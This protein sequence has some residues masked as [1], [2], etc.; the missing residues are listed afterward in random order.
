MK[1][2][3]MIMMPSAGISVQLAAV[4]LAAATIQSTLSYDNTQHYYDDSGA[5]D[6]GNHKHQQQPEVAVA[7]TAHHRHHHRHRGIT[8]VTI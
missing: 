8:V 6:S 5:I 3:S 4:V 7:I 1:N 2:A